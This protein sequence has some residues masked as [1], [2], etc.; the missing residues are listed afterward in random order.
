LSSGR[1]ETDVFPAELEEIRRRR[2]IGGLPLPDVSRGPAADLG[3][4]G[5][6]LS[7]G[8]IR[9]AAVSLGL[10][11]V[12]A[13]QGHLTK[14]DYVSTVSGGGLTGSC[15]SSVLNS[16]DT[17]TANDRFPLGFVP[18]EPERPAVKYLRN[19]GRYLTPAGLLDAFRPTAVVLRGLVDNLAVLLPLLIIAVQ[20]TEL[21]NT[22]F[23]RFGLDRL[24]F[25]PLAGLGVFAGVAL[26]QLVL[27]RIFPR[28]F[29][30]DGRNRYELLLASALLLVILVLVLVPLFAFVQA[31]MDLS[32]QRVGVFLDRCALVLGI[33]VALILALTIVG[34]VF[35]GLKSLM[36]TIRTMLIGLMG[37][38]FVFALF[39]L[40]TMYSVDS[41]VLPSSVTA[42]LNSGA[43]TPALE[44]ELDQRGF[45]VTIGAR[46][47]H[48]IR[49][50]YQWW[51]INADA[52]E[53]I[54]VNWRGTV[55]LTNTLLWDG[56]GE[57]LF[58]SAGLLGLLWAVWFA[59]P[60]LTSQHA[61]FRDRLSRTFIFSVRP[62]GEV[63][64]WDTL[65]LS[66]LNAPG[67]S[68]PYH[69][70]NCTLNLQ[71]STSPSLAGRHSD[72]FLLS[73]HFVGANTTGYCRTEEIERFDKHLDLGT[74]MAISGAGLSPNAGTQSVGP[75]IFL[76][77]LLDLRLDYWLPN[78]ALVRDRSALAQVRLRTALG[79]T[80]LFREAFG[81]LDAHGA[82]VNVSD[83]GQIENLAVYELLRRRCRLIICVDASEDSDMSCPCLADLLRYARIDF[84]IEIDINIDPLRRG[85]TGDSAAHWVTGAIHYGANE[86]GH[87]VYIKASVSGDEPQAVRDFRYRDPAFPQDPSSNQSYPE[88]QF[89]AYRALGEHI[90]EMWLETEKPF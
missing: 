82:H 9:S 87:F 23:Y 38:A 19:H 43:I 65:K 18:G 61:F 7:G 70:I 47:A 26:L 57:W 69:L 29:T 32:W 46:I 45:P 44:Q 41:P 8:G 63:R 81:L 84:G 56:P 42:D 20:G 1:F 33:A 55:R 88:S 21:L 35:P 80:A 89:E 50:G 73:R 49:S 83:G 75:L 30:W 76:F 59:N 48:R 22:F 67:S 39:L 3:L 64:H 86:T 14:I 16:A 28:R 24:R 54:V 36:G 6:A 5:L 15:L 85:P 71:G 53:V 66:R 27:Y 68:A 78:P 72:F 34:A 90:T 37:Y 10:V 60:N 11:Q 62:D 79:P 12:L 51:V 13:A 4:I 77:T 58:F 52:G 40:L 25:A 31:A 2:Q 17:S 74:A